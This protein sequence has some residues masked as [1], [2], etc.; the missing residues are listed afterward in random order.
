[1]RAK[2][3]S[4]LPPELE[5]KISPWMVNIAEVAG[6]VGKS[7]LTGV[8]GFFLYGYLGVSGS[9]HNGFLFLVGPWVCP[10]VIA[11]LFSALVARRHLRVFRGS[12]FAE[13]SYV[14]DD[15]VVMRLVALLNSDEARRHLWRETLKLSS[16]LFVILGIAAI[17]QRDSLNW[18][19]PSLQNQFLLHQRHGEPGFWFWS[20][21]FSCSGVMFFVLTSDYQ[22]W[23]LLTWAKRESDHHIVE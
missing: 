22:R 5:R 1:M 20:G 8:A 21:L 12:P 3:N 10:C 6:T 17:L 18:A 11:F 23:C 9:D 19:F 4:I 7:V 14:K 15:P 2:N 16:I 13:H